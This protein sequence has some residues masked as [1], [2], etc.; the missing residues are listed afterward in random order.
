MH[1]SQRFLGLWAVVLINWDKI[2]FIFS[3]IVYF[4]IISFRGED[5]EFS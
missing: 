5:Y 3:A 1:L 2:P 4:Y